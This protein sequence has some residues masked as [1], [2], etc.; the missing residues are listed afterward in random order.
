[1][2]TLK[3]QTETKAIKEHKCSYCSEKIT[4]GST[5]LKS[6]HKHDGGLYD[7]K[8]HKYCHGLAN[9]LNM[10]D[11]SDEGVTGEMFAEYVHEFHDGLLINLFPKDEI[12]KY[13]DIISQL[14]FVSFHYKLWYVIRHFSKLKETVKNPDK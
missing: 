10:F 4:V 7:W 2:E 3:Y 9:D 14:R 6:T 12:M 11:D 8:A 1:M 5:Y 13:S